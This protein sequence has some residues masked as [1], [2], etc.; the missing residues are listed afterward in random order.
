LHLGGDSRV[1]RV[2]RDPEKLDATGVFTYPTVAEIDAQKVGI[3]V[4]RK[5]VEAAWS[6]DPQMV[7][8]V[9]DGAPSH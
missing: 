1:R 8:G 3:D 6:V 2:E 5:V 4:G 9:T 7:D